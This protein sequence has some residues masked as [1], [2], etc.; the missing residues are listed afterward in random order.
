M[1]RSRRTWVMFALAAVVALGMAVPAFATVG[2]S[3]YLTWDS[4]GGTNGTSPHGGFTTTTNKCA[5]CHSVHNAD[6]FGE[7]LL[8]GP[9]ADS[10][11]YCHV[12]GSG[13]YSQVYGGVDT[14]YLGT[15]L[16]NAHNSWVV[17]A[18]NYGVTCSDCHQVHGADNVM[19]ANA[20]LTSKILV[21]GKTYSG[22]NYDPF[23]YPPLSTDSSDTALTKWCTACH[24]SSIGVGYNYFNGPDWSSGVADDSGMPLNNAAS[25]VMTNDFASYTFPDG[26]TGQVAWSGSAE[27][28]SCHSSGYRTSAWPHF[29]PGQ[30]FLVSAGSAASA[31]PDPATDTTDDGV[32]LRCHRDGAGAGVGLDW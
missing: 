15:D 11:N 27:C 16:G 22:S 17:G 2:D 19:T 13:G 14:N 1:D 12:G 26:S 7:L 18:T 3:G 28:S 10:C 5:V 24:D 20:Y 21:G 9:V 25:H 32:C 23:A 6:P 30:R 29:T 31:T 4:M 8:R